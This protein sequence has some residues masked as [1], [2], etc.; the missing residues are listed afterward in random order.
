[1]TKY[2]VAS[3]LNGDVSPDDPTI[4]ESISTSYWPL[5]D[6]PRLAVWMGW[7]ML[8]FIVGALGSALAINH[9]YWAKSD[10]L[11]TLIIPFLVLVSVMVC[12][13]GCAFFVWIWR[14]IS[15]T[16]DPRLAEVYRLD[17][18]IQ[19]AKLSISGVI[20]S[21]SCL[22]IIVSTKSESHGHIGRSVALSCL[23]ITHL[24]YAVLVRASLVD[25]LKQVMVGVTYIA[26]CIVSVTVDPSKEV[27][28]L[29]C[30][31]GGV[32]T[33]SAI[34]YAIARS[35]FYTIACLSVSLAAFSPSMSLSVTGHE[36]FVSGCLLAGLLMWAVGEG[37]RTADSLSRMAALL[38]GTWVGTV[39]D[40]DYMPLLSA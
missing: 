4:D 37:Q 16:R 21:L 39:A 35:P 32:L 30:L 38:F 36:H 6:V 14:L 11:E 29:L 28:A 19:S 9:Y 22:A 13:F 10:W 26:G 23:G 20:Y 3:V 27:H 8:L 18:F 31:M 2:T 5:A 15:V 33:V 1:M 24:V 17:F 40:R 25:S 12:V 34:L 7:T